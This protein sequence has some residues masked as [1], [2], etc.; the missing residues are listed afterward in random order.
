MALAAL[1]VLACAPCHSSIVESYSR[2]GMGRAFYRLTGASRIEDFTRNNTLVHV[3]SK[4]RFTM[5]E[6]GGRFFIRR[7]HPNGTL[8]KEIHYV[9]GSGNHARGYVHRTPQGRLYTM[10]VSWYT[11]GSGR[12]QMAPGYDRPE[13][14]DFRRKI[15][16]ECFFCHNAYPKVPANAERDPADP[17]FLDPLPE[18]IDCT[19]C[20]G[21]AAPHLRQPRPGNIL[22]PKRLPAAR[23]LEICLQC[24]LEPTSHA[25]PYVL[26][27][28]DRPFFSYR[29]GEPLQDYMLFFDHP[30]GTPYA[31]KFEVVSAA[32]RF[33]KSACFKMSNGRMTCTTCHDPHARGVK[34]ACQSCHAKA[35]NPDKDCALCHMAKRHPEDAPLTL[36]TDHYIQRIPIRADPP[37]LPEYK[38]PVVPYYPESA[39]PFYLAVAQVKEGV[40]LKDGILRLRKLSASFPAPDFSLELAEAYRKSGAPR[41]AI[42]FY[43]QA[44]K[45][46]PSLL[47]AWRGLALAKYPAPEPAIEGL[48]HAPGDAFLLA[49]LGMA[50]ASEADLEAAIRADPD[51]AESYV[52]LGA[53]LGRKGDSKR[54]IELFRQALAIDP[55]NRAAEA[56]LKLA[57]EKVKAK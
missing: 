11:D 10:P 22:N 53:L 48:K 7:E 54:A 41:E 4:S 6:R 23:Q 38:G 16:Y 44:L 50:R 27:R 31:D 57:G 55:R 12:W 25:L 19:R 52:N 3:P 33:R 43:E 5:T 15:S 20:H 45:S 30:P 42:P 32:Y 26:R 1:A 36:M 49:L 39:D 34:N 56:N 2:T 21:D 9:L 40:H 28:Y 51:M 13:H 24:H 18:G 46:M 35:H 37:E 47:A 14:F 8:E 29:P 17:V